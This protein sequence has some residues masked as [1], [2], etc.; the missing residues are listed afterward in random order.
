MLQTQSFY[1]PLLSTIPIHF[2]VPPIMEKESEA[3]RLR[4]G[5][6]AVARL[7]RSKLADASARRGQQRGEAERINETTRA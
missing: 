2:S 5:R 7:A 1:L 3:V 6:L 4:Q